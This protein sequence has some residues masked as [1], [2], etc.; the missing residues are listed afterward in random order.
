VTA[1]FVLIHLS[2]DPTAG[3]TSPGASP[4]QQQLIRERFGLDQPLAIQYVTY[5]G[6]LARGDFGDSWRAGR[7]AIEA[8]LERLPA[9]LRLTGAALAIALFVAVPLGIA[10]GARP[11][12]RV[13]AIASSIALLGQAVPGFMLGTVL[14]LIFAVHLGWLPSSGGAGWQSLLLPS[15]ALAAFPAALIV[16]LLRGALN[17][18]LHADYVRVARGKGLSPGAVVRGHALR[19]ALLPVLAYTGIQAGFLLGGAIVIEGVF[20]YPGIGQLALGAVA[21]RDLPVVQAVVIV[22]ALLIVAVNAAVD[23]LARVIDPRLRLGEGSGA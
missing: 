16:R 1:V 22:V 23:V 4:E 21:D 13:D 20:A 10:A 9:T 7:P 19:N 11:H 17:E 18:A 14:I 5:L 2:G 12:G 3:F 6:N 8:V 15:V